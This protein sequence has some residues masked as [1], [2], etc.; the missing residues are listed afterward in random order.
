MV[1]RNDRFCKTWV[2]QRHTV[3]KVSC[4]RPRCSRPNSRITSAGWLSQAYKGRSSTVRKEVDLFPTT[5]VCRKQVLRIEGIRG[6]CRAYPP[7]AKPTLTSSSMGKRARPAKG[8]PNHLLKHVQAGQ[9]ETFAKSLV[10]QRVRI[11][12]VAKG[13]GRPSHVREGLVRRAEN[14]VLHRVYPQ[15]LH[16]P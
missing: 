15:E 12:K 3:F 2:K 11:A 5:S 10:G 8:S 7:S 14:E 9:S 4:S 1:P 6:R 16:Q 13:R